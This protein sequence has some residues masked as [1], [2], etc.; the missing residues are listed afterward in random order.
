[1]SLP[2]TTWDSTDDTQKKGTLVYDDEEKNGP[3]RSLRQRTGVLVYLGNHGEWKS[4]SPGAWSSWEPRESRRGFIPGDVRGNII[5]RRLV[6]LIIWPL[7]IHPERT[8]AVDA[9]KEQ[10]QLTA[11]CIDFMCPVTQN[12]ES[13]NEKEMARRQ[14]RGRSSCGKW[15]VESNP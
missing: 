3:S 6:I 7:T 1:M 10:Q 14:I 11:E 15:D 12:Q 5:R 8:E 4:A 9:V 13:E 2:K